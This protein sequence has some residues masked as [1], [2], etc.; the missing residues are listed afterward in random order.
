MRQLHAIPVSEAE[1][2]GIHHSDTNRSTQDWQDFYADIEE[3][4]FPLLLR[5]QR[6]AIATHFE[7]V[8]SGRLEMSCRP[9]FISGDMGCYHIL[10]D[11][12]QKALSGIIDFGTA[13]IGD[14]ATDIAILLGQYGE[15]L[16][17]LLLSSYSDA[18][19]CMERA[20]FWAGTFELQWA[21]ASIK[22]DNK[23]LLL[24]HPGGARDRLPLCQ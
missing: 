14:P 23:E 18:S 3:T 13:G 21:L 15:S 1:K 19:Q 4:L 20:R 9:T 2:V 17:E 6:S 11:E 22:N 16:V 24:A 5:H 12:A 8:L 10:F 7:P